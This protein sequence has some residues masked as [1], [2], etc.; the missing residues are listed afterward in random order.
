MGKTTG[1]IVPIPPFNISDVLPPFTG[2][3]SAQS[4]IGQTMSPYWATPSDVIARFATS[5]QRIAILQGWLN[6][7]SALHGF[8]FTDGWQWVD[9]SFVEN[10]GKE[11]SDIDVITIANRPPTLLNTLDLRA[12]VQANPNVFQPAQSKAV[13]KVDAYLV[14]LGGKLDS[15]ISVCMYW[16]QLFSHQ[17]VTGLWKG[18]VAVPLNP[19]DDANAQ[20]QL[21]TLQTGHGP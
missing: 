11:P 4:V 1:A 15:L 21:T 7:R 9:G 5:A 19:A 12:F 20:A 13:H 10:T 3:T 16:V 2:P 8:G 17:K 18:V 14:D 6:H